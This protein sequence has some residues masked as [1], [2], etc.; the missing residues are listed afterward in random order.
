[1]ADAR[2]VVGID[3][4]TTNCVLAYVD[5]ARWRP[6]AESAADRSAR[7]AAARQARRGRGAHAAAVVRLLPAANEFK[8]ESLALPWGQP[9]HVVG[10]LARARGAE[11]PARVVAS[12]KSWLCS[13]GPTRARR[14]CRGTRPRTSPRLSPVDAEA[15]YLRH[16]RAAWDASMPAPLAEQDVYLAVPASFDAAARELTVRS[17]RAG[18]PVGRAGSSRSRRRR[19]TPGS[20]TAT[21]AWR[22]AVQRRR[23]RPGVRRRRRDHR[24]DARRGRRGGRQPG[25]RAQGGRRSHPARRRQH[26]PGARPRR[27]R[28]ARRGGHGARR[29]AAARPG[30]RLPRGE[31]APA[32]REG[33]GR[34][35][36]SWCSA[37]RARS[38][39]AR[40]ARR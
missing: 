6:G 9:E 25:A 38:S 8:P 32:R 40:Y 36:R 35:R 29:L 3:L 31:G 34:R 5:T 26:G 17:R 23:R 10:E 14:S 27:A 1:M 24:S 15:A 18:G 21:V 7:G 37:A 30:A 39:A 19:S 12:A 4:G 28:A 13:V 2:Y 33:A 16:L 22:Q 20:R 11:V